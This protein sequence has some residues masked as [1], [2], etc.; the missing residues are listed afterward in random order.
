MRA[1]G[2]ISRLHNLAVK[3]EH[4]RIRDAV[5]SGRIASARSPTTAVHDAG[6]SGDAAFGTLQDS[7]NA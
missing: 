7:S 2:R 6:K 3:G 1:T 5:E 4:M